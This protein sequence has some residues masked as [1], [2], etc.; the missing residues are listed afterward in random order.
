[1]EGLEAEED[2][3]VDDLPN[4]RFAEE[5]FDVEV[6]AAAPV[7]DSATSWDDTAVQYDMPDVI[8][9]FIV[10]FQKQVSDG[11]V[12]EIHSI[13]ETSFNKLTERK[14]FAALRLSLDCF[15]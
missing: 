10:F 12:H 2:I 7:D 11:N 1:M 6:A 3:A 15:A 9:S 4:F 5:S 8:R 13:Y 14:H